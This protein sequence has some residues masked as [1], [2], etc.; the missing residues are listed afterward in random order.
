MRAAG[1][2]VLAYICVCML[3]DCSGSGS[4]SPDTPVSGVAQVTAASASARTATLAS[5][6]QI[7]SGETC[8]VPP[9]LELWHQREHLP[10]RDLPVGPGDVIDVSASEIDEIQNQ[11]VRVSPEGT[12]ELPLVGTLQVA[13]LSENELR[14]AL[15]QRL[16]VYMKHPRIEL[17]VENYRSRGVA[18]TGAV[19]KP[20]SYDM[21][22]TGDSI[23]D[24]IGL[25]GGL[26]P[27]AAQKVVFFPVSGTESNGGSGAVGSG[28]ATNVVA[29]RF[30]LTKA[31][32]PVGEA[33]DEQSAPSGG[34][35]TALTNYS[36]TI[37]LTAG[38]Q[39]ACLRIP[40]RPG[41]VVLVPVAG[42]VM[43]QGWVNSPGAFP[44]T[45]GMTVLG[46]ISAAGGASFSW[47]AELI[48]PDADGGKTITEYSLSS[49][50]DNKQH[51]TLVQSGDVVLVEKSV[52]G[53]VPYAIYGIFSRFGSGVAL[54]IPY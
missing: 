46:A 12:I 25:A 19:Q 29:P 38:A 47:H 33:V 37:D 17:F 6:I 23:L 40:T 22:D 39:E 53:A 35:G 2:A 43:V 52:V 5:N 27:G 32:T 49:L 41:D 9:I 4:E 34:T 3:S 16:Q 24:M 14:D 18:V 54:P 42:E 26:A 45:P 8:T 48:R 10:V 21:S 11:R 30:E 51:D 20:G 1:L 36:V 50:E 13:G 28:N 15:V 31:E 44:I 7:P